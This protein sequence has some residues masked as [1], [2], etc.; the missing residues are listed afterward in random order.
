[1]L[2][3]YYFMLHIQ[4]RNR[5]FWRRLAC[6]SLLIGSLLVP[7]AT[8]GDTIESYPQKPIK[9]MVPAKPGGGWDQLGRIIQHVIAD[10]NLSPVSVEVINRGG[11]GG[12]IGLAELVGRHYGDPYMIMISGGVMTGAVIAHDSPFSLTDTTPLARLVSEYEIIAVPF[13]SPYQSLADLVAAFKKN[14]DDFIWAGGSAGGIDH[15]LVGLFA[16]A[17]G[18]DPK[19]INYI[20][21]T[22]GGEAGAAVMGGQVDAGASGLAEW[23]GLAKGGKMRILG[24]SAPKRISGYEI[25]TLIEGGVNVIMENWRSVM[26]SSNIKREHRDWLIGIFSKLRNTPEWQDILKRNGWEDTFLTGQAFNEFI[27]HDIDNSEAIL[28]KL[29]ISHGGNG[30][31]VIGPYTFPIT[32]GFGLLVS[33]LFIWR[34]NRISPQKESLPYKGETITDDVADRMS[35]KKLYF[36]IGLIT[37]YI[38]LLKMI[39][40]LVATP[41]FIMASALLMGSRKWKRDAIVSLIVTSAIFVIFSQILNVDIP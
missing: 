25:P 3:G 18:L 7:S 20:A 31:S 29:G 23:A 36:G 41:I 14:P 35:W 19:K 15:M 4:F 39:G 34:G 28:N 40:F 5:F 13:N 27:Q 6:G 8:A 1:M 26:A 10:K 33:F 37:A 2:F 38:L 11:A 32:I 12:T 16:D 22:G 17:I 30:Y 21:Y 24:I 9:I